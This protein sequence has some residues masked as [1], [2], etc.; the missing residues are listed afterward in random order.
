MSNEEDIEK[1]KSLISTGAEIAGA[2]VGGAIG[3]FAA[4]PAGAAGAGTLGVIVAKAGA[5]LLGDI[6]ERTMSEREKVRVGATA[7]IAFDKI[8]KN[9][10]AGAEPRR[11]GF[12]ESSDGERSK[13]EEVLEG[14]L[15]R[16]REEYEEKKIALLGNFYANMVC[17]PGVSVEEANYYLRLFDSLTYRQLC[18]ICLIFMKPHYP[19]FHNLRSTDYRT[20]NQNM[21]ASTVTLLQEIL[22]IYNLGL[23]CVQN[24]NGEGYSALL[25]WHDVIPSGLQLTGLGDRFRGLFMGGGNL[26]LSDIESVAN[27]L[28]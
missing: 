13:A 21:S 25:G 8:E 12:F 24:S 5:K 2:A 15:R 1:T 22:A 28:R 20:N 17:S 4:G 10:K 27:F 26:V 7:A 19:S 3:F 18:V 23:V 9:I 11:D 16:A 14:T 6:A